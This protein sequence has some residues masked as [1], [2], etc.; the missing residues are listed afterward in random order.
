[1][2]KIFP[3]PGIERGDNI[4]ESRLA[5]AEAG[6][7]VADAPVHPAVPEAK[8]TISI[9]DRTLA[10]DLVKAARLSELFGEFL[11]VVVGAAGAMFMNQGAEEKLGSPKLIKLLGLGKPAKKNAGYRAHEPVGVRR[12]AGNVYHRRGDIM[13]F[14]YILNPAA[15]RGVGS[16]GRNPPEG[17]TGPQGNNRQGIRA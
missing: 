17:S 15:A 5:A 14:K 16:A 10:A 6:R 11:L 12:T 2:R 13:G 7:I 9:G 4:G 3:H 1:L 8:G